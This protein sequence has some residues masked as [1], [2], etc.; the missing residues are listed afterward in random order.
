MTLALGDQE[1]GFGVLV[2]GV[3]VGIQGAS[4]LGDQRRDPQGAMPVEGEGKVHELPDIA[5]VIRVQWAN[6]HETP[7]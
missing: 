3:L 7:G 6:A 1:A 5:A 2:K 4:G